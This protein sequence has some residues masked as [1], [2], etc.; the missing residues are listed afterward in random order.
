[1]KSRLPATPLEAL[2]ISGVLKFIV[3]TIHACADVFGFWKSP[4]KK[5][6]ADFEDMS[7]LAKIYW[8]YKSKNPVL[9][10]E[11]GAHLEAFF[12]NHQKGL[13]LP[14]SFEKRHSLTF[15]AVGDLIKVEGLENS[16]D[17]LYEKVVDLI[18][19]RDISYANLESQLTTRDI[20]GY[21]FSEKEAP[22]LCL[23]KEQYDVLKGYRGKQFTLMH[24][25]CNHTFDVGMEGVETTLAQLEKDHIVDLGTNRNASDQQKGRIIEKNGIKIGFVSATYGLN[26]KEVPG[27]KEHMVNMV[28]FHRGQ[29]GR[30]DSDRN[31]DLTLLNNQISYCKDQGC[32]MV[33]ASIHWG[34]EYEFFPRQHQ[35]EIAHTLV[36]SGVDVIVS[37]HAHV[38]QPVEYYRPRRDPD[39]TAVIAYSLG[40]LTTSFSAPHLVLSGV[41]NLTIVKGSV[42]GEEKTFVQDA[43]LVPVVQRDFIESDLPVIQLEKLETFSAGKDENKTREEIDYISAVEGY[44][45]LVL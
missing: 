43:Q 35:V 11:K 19:D 18:F 13:S 5:A 31:I 34:Y 23:S 39:R 24:T 45:K 10:G 4:S 33:I 41:L 38:V 3:K 40:N 15:S 26:G 21:T 14:E 30:V 27:G 22:P 1:M 44:A 2:S 8:G 9:K 20:G 7:L 42:N 28:R 6:A 25:A 16:R 32:D 17:K 36:E 29:K 12:K 37:H